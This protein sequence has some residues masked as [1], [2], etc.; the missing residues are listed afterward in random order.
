MKMNQ[1]LIIF[2]ALAVLIPILFTPLL[3][4]GFLSQE[5][6][7]INVLIEFHTQKNIN[8]IKQDIQ[9]DLFG[10]FNAIAQEFRNQASYTTFQDHNFTL[11]DSDPA[12]MV[13]DIG[14]L[15]IGGSTLK[16]YQISPEIQYNGT[17]VANQTQFETELNAQVSE[18]RLALLQYIDDNNGLS[19]KS[20]LKFT[21]GEVEIDELF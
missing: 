14:D 13:W 6:G 12:E 16:G 20:Y 5:R 3:T 17:S 19:V 18:L 9:N 2:I 10:R 7:E 4:Y 21:F 15:I 11:I 1:N 8:A